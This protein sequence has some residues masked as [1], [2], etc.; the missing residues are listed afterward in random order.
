MSVKGGPDG[1]MIASF[2]PVVF[3]S[4]LASHTIQDIKE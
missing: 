4:P 1:R 2:N 3:E